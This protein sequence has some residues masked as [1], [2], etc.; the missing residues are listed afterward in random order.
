MYRLTAVT[1]V[2][3]LLLVACGGG[4]MD[5]A[6]HS[7][8]GAAQAHSDGHDHSHGATAGFGVV[9]D[10]TEADTEI[11][12]VANDSLRFV[13]DLFEVA[14]AGTVKF[15]ITNKGRLEHEFV[16]GD[17]SYQEAHSGAMGSMTHD[18]GNG[19]LLPPGAT[20]EVTWTFTS[21]GEIL[22]ACHVDDHYRAGMVGSISVK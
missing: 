3:S 1:G 9:G 4:A 6:G 18:E 11:K 17:Q 14:F 2:L 10:P 19:V 21:A 8:G 7:G 13:P 22:F 20:G 15:V 12:V 5:H 16:L